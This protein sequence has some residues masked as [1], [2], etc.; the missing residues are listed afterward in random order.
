MAVRG[1][2]LA[3][4]M[5]DLLDDTSELKDARDVAR[6]LVPLFSEA[7]GAQQ[8]SLQVLIPDPDR[9]ATLGVLGHQHFS[10]T[11]LVRADAP[12]LVPLLNATEPLWTRTRQETQDVMG[13]MLGEN[14]E[15]VPPVELCT[16]HLLAT[17]LR[18]SGR[19]V[20]TVMLGSGPDGFRL[21]DVTVLS[22]LAR[23]AGS[24]V[25]RA[26][27]ATVFD[28]TGR[29]S[30][31]VLHP[32]RDTATAGATPSSPQSPELEPNVGSDRAMTVPR[33][34]TRQLE[35][36]AAVGGGL[37]NRQ[38][39]EDLGLSVHTVRTHRHHLMDLFD[40]HTSTV[41]ISRARS[42]GILTD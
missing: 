17:P 15:R 42:A 28:A 40:A 21:A 37:T 10:S 29:L 18:R 41:L 4:R 24:V 23:L 14:L 5:V 11:L 30:T 19:V 20:G 6:L 35:V 36:L 13:R 9:F 33:L 12:G 27:I 1:L 22:L 39:A 32:D 3:T 7:L 31:L 25:S 16:P 2:D 8:V 34:T 38:I 26:E